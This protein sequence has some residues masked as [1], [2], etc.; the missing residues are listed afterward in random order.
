MADRQWQPGCA[1]SALRSSGLRPRDRLVLLLP[2]LMWVL[3][4]LI[5]WLLV[6]RL[7]IR[8]LRRLQQ[9]VSRYSPATSSE[10]PRKLGPCARNPGAARRVRPGDRPRR[11]VRARDGAQRSKASGGWSAKSITG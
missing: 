10:L 4:A 9:A 3:A 2:V 1:A 11:P 5:T 6:T 7:L 8:P